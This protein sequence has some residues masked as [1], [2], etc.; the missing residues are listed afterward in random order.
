MLAEEQAYDYYPE[1]IVKI[2]KEHELILPG[3]E[4]DFTRFV[5]GC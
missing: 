5:R 4:Q 1:K 2:M 3:E